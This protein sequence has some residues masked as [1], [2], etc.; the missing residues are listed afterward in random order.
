MTTFAPN[1]LL[2]GV[3]R[4]VVAALDAWSYR[5]AKARA[6][7]RRLRTEARKAAA[8]PQEAGPRWPTTWGD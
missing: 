1:G 3:M 5:I 6:E 8:A 7:R 4:H 2:G